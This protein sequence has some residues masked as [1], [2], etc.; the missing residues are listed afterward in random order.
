MRCTEFLF[1]KKKKKTSPFGGRR[2]C[3]FKYADGPLLF[4]QHLFTFKK[5]DTFAID[6]CVRQAPAPL[7]QHPAGSS[8]FSFPFCFLNK[9][10][11]SNF[12]GGDQWAL[13]IFSAAATAWPTWVDTLCGWRLFPP[14]NGESN[15]FVSFCHA[16]LDDIHFQY[17]GVLSFVIC[18]SSFFF[19][20]ARVEQISN[21][22]PFVRCSFVFSIPFNVPTHQVPPGGLEPSPPSGRVK[23][24]FR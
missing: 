20:L 9:M 19:I 4:T 18:F 13:S 15:L 6:L 21:G 3:L 14:K 1:F 7:R 11:S 16:T 23:C 17:A 12:V 10:S 5:I 22:A 8:K 2:S 24:H